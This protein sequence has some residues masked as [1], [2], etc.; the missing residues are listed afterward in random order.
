M[1]GKGSGLKELGSDWL[2][3]NIETTIGVYDWIGIRIVDVFDGGEVVRRVR[4]RTKG[5]DDL[6]GR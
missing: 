3:L 6:T 5:I 1:D 2:W 4:D